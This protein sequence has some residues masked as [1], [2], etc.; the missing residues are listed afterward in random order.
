M[1]FSKSTHLIYPKINIISVAKICVL[2]SVIDST[3]TKNVRSIS[4]VN[5]IFGDHKV[6][7]MRR[8][9]RIR[10][11]QAPPLALAAGGLNDQAISLL[12]QIFFNHLLVPLFKRHSQPLFCSGEVS[13][14]VAVYVQW[15]PSPPNK[16]AQTVNEAVC[17]QGVCNFQMYSSC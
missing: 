12:P 7:R 6:K 10:R 17:R 8:T 2:T 14:I 16:P 15:L 9:E 4:S 5:G 1:S 3:S 13:A 11:S